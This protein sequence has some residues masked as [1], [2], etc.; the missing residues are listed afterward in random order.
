MVNNSAIDN[1]LNNA[2][3]VRENFNYFTNLTQDYDMDNSNTTIDSCNSIISSQSKSMM[4]I[5][6]LFI[7]YSIVQYIKSNFGSRRVHS[8]GLKTYKGLF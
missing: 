6:G 2:N 8:N 4:V 7:F 3:F 5:I 1:D